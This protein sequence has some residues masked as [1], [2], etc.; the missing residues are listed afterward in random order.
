MGRKKQ[1]LI[2]VDDPEGLAAWM[3]RYLEWMAV[4]NYSDQTIVSRKT[5]LHQFNE[6]CKER[7]LKRP[8]EITKPILERYQRYLFHYRQ[9]NG[10]PLSFSRQAAR[11]IALRGLFKWL[12]KQNHILYNP[13]SELELPRKER[14]LPKAILTREEAETLINQPDTTAAIGIR[15]R[16]ILET[17]YSTGIRRAELASLDLYDIDWERETLFI[18]QGK[19]KKDRLVPIGECAL[20]WIETYQQTV[21]PELLVDA[22]EKALFL[23]YKGARLV[24]DGLSF[25]V[26]RYIN[27]AGIEKPGSCHL[28]RHTMA[29][30]MLENGADVRFIQE[31][32]GHENLD[33]TQQYTHA[34]SHGERSE[35]W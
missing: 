11:L 2:H 16:A 4:Q 19:G 22:A 13:A 25:L 3:L 12:T 23:S 30:V 21:R 10:S 27:K 31:I 32:L 18:H 14:R 15:D 33:T 6:W 17:F 9:P 35:G 7:S 1:S 28:F 8:Q 34:A 20:S 29:T 24:K 5:D 26:R